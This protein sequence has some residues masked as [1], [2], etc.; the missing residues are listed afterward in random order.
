MRRDLTVFLT[1]TALVLGACASDDNGSDANAPTPTVDS[2]T[3]GPVVTE[4]SVPLPATTPQLSPQSTAP[5]VTDV[6]EPLTTA[7]E[8]TASTGS[9]PSTAELTA[10]RPFN[11]FVPTTYESTT[12]TPLVLLLHGY[13]ASGDIQESYFKFEPLAV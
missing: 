11:V 13:T 10:D 12:P 5:P 1:V 7:G 9:P 8:P 4:P 3:T 6:P 2:A